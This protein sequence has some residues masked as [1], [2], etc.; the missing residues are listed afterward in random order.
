MAFE[1]ESGCTD[2]LGQNYRMPMLLNPPPTRRPG[3]MEIQLL[4]CMSVLLWWCHYLSI[5]TVCMWRAGGCA[6][7]CV[8]DWPT[9]GVVGHVQGCGQMR[10]RGKERQQGN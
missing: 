6:W 5:I 4:Q 1:G 7:H 2:V 10:E 3:L 8:S 9:D